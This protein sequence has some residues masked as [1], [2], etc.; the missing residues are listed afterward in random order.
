[1]LWPLIAPFVQ[2][3]KVHTSCSMLSRRH[4]SSRC[5][6]LCSMMGGSQCVREPPCSNGVYG[7]SYTHD[8]I[9]T[10]VSWDEDPD[11]IPKDILESFTVLICQRQVPVVAQS[12][13]SF[14]TFSGIHPC[15]YSALYPPCPFYPFAPFPS[16]VRA[17]SFV[18]RN[19]L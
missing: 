3:A 8:Q 15:F 19:D 17:A 16:A 1:M 11:I 4:T 5:G 13:R 6:T 18:V 10:L 14:I 7:A 12:N 2:V 9:N